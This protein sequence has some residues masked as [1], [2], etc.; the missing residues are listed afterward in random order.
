VLD[1]DL[2]IMEPGDDR[3][4]RLARGGNIPIGYYK[5]PE[6]TAKTFV[7]AADGNR[8]VVPGDVARVE[9]DGA[10]TLL[11]RGSGCINS[12]GEKIFPEE[13]E[14]ALKAHDAVF[15]AVVV[16]VPDA[17]WGQA[18]AAVVETRSGFDVPTLDQL[19][20]HCRERLAGYKV[21]RHLHHVDRI[22]R[23]PSGKPD[24]RWAATVATGG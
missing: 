22:E 6:K 24:Y 15:D 9:A 13:V 17:R 10:I 18:V 7:T 4:G 16:G 1:D 2:R 5:D 11:G 21:P 14:S 19:D 20:A 3:L 23:S 8:Y 12:G